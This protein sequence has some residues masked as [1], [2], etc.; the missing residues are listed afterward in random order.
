MSLEAGLLVVGMLRVTSFSTK[1][2][3]S[4]APPLAKFLSVGEDLFH[5]KG[6]P[7]ETQPLEALRGENRY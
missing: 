5:S 7:P 2:S 4:L 1:L 6:P 3:H